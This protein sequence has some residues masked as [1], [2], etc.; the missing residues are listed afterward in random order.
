MADDLCTACGFTASECKDFARGCCKNCTHDLD[1]KV[2]QAFVRGFT[3]GMGRIQRL[4]LTLHTMTG[5]CI[6]AECNRSWPCPTVE[7]I[8]EEE[9]T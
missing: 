1:P 8:T 7:A 3:E 6:C 9:E 4:V 5:D 2:V